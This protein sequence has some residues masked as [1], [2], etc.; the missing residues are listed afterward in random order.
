MADLSFDDL[1]PATPVAAGAPGGNGVAVSIGGGPEVEAAK[2]P[3]PAVSFD[4][5]VPKGYAE[6]KAKIAKNQQALKDNNTRFAGPIGDAMNAAG[7]FTSQVA[8]NTG[9]SDEVAGGINYLVQ[10]AENL[11]RNVLGKPILIP[12]SSAAKA[13]I[14]YEREQQAAYAKAHPTANVLAGAASI[15]ATGSPTG[16]AAITSPLAAGAAVAAQNAPFA[17][18][19]QKG[20]VLQRLPGAA[21]EEALSFGTGAALTAGANVLGRHAVAAAANPTDQRVLSQEGVDLT[22]GQ[23]AGGLGKRVE[24]AATSLPLTGASINARR[25]DSIASFDRAA[26]NRAL[27]PIGETLPGDVGREGVK[28]TNDLISNAYTK[29]LSGVTV[30]PDAQFAQDVGQVLARPNLPGT[31]KDDLNSIAQNTLGRFNGPIDGPT[32]KSIDAELS[33]MSR[34]ADNA[35]AS[36]P[37]QRYLRDAIDSLRD[38][39]FGALQ[40]S[41]PQA[42]DQVAKANEAFANFARIRHA[43]QQ[44]GAENG[45]FT[46]AQL[47]RSVQAGDN[48]AGNQAF[49]RGEALM[50]DLSEKAKNVLPSKVPDSGTALRSMIGMGAYGGV[51]A[52]AGPHAAAA[53]LAADLA[54]AAIYSR[55]V[56]GLINSIYRASSPGQAQA[57]LSRLARLAARSPGLVPVY[58]EAARRLG[59]PL[60]RAADPLATQ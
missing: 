14:D 60:P 43:A 26:M 37:T 15:A 2:R 59:V 44:I 9:A 30:A 23:M 7:D 21:A 5:L 36:Q 46:P 57:A 41:N 10:G 35:S 52:A 6:A 55:P 12:A 29:A 40:R 50:Q 17:L 13:A 11:G 28:A 42:A 20:N 4:D 58:R 1:I 49:S 39:N 53:G 32:W 47:Q 22:M 33:S 31:V 24:D 8:R 51:G 19:R 16:A 38:A 3:Q 34:A 48:S 27:A 45:V 25:A 54:G 18:A 56:Q